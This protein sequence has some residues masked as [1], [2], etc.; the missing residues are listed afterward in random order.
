MNNKTISRL[1]AAAMALLLCLSPLSPALAAEEGQR[2]TI[3]TAEDLLDLADKCRLDAWSQGK[4]VVLTADIS[5]E[6]IDFSGIP[7]F[8][9]TFQGG[10]H[11]ISGLNIT[12]SDAPAGLFR[13]VQP[14]GQIRELNVSGSVSP[15]GTA[16]AVGGIAGENGG[17]ITGCGFTGTVTGK[18]ST[19]G[20][21]G[22]NTASGRV[23]NCWAS[24][25]VTGDR[26]TGGIAG[27][28]EGVLTA[29]VNRAYI[30]TDNADKALHLEDLDLGVMEDLG[31]IGDLDTMSAAADTGGVVGYSSGT[32]DQCSNLG[33]VGYP[34][35]GYNIGG[36]AGRSCGYIRS[37]SNQAAVVGRKDVGGVVG[38]MEPYVVRE[39]T[40]D[41]AATLRQQLDSL[42][43]ALNQA[44]ADAGSG[45]GAL[46]ARLNAMAG[47]ADSAAGAL[48]GIQTNGFLGGGIASGSKVEV[49]L[50]HI[51]QG[52]HGLG[53]GAGVS[54][55]TSINGLTSA[56]GMLTGQMRLLSGEASNLTDAL[57][58]DLL[59]VN[60][61]VEALADT[62]FDTVLS[63]DG[64]IMV[65]SSQ[66]DIDAVTS[67]KVLGCASS[68]GINGDINVGG[69]AGAM[70]LEYALDPE[71]DV[72]SALEGGV[73]RK[74]EMKAILQNCKNTGT[75]EARHS[76]AGGV[77]GKMDL[78]LITYCGSYGDV[79]SES[80]SY[81]GGVAGIASST[82]RRS[83]AKCT[84]SGR[85]YVGG[86]VGS[87]VE[88]TSSGS[89]S[90]VASCVSMVAIPT[91]TQYAGA[92][93]GGSP[94]T[95]L[96]NY[97]ISDDL[98]GINGVS[99]AGIAQPVAYS[100]M[101]SGGIPQPKAAAPADPAAQAGEAAVPAEPQQPEFLP[102]EFRDFTLKFVAD[103]VVL[104]QTGFAYGD[105]F[106]QDFFPPLPQKEGYYAYWDKTDLQELKF[107]TVVSAV[108]VQYN[109]AL[110][111]GG[112]YRTDGR[113]IFFAEGKFDGGGTLTASP[114][115]TTPDAFPAL[116]KTVGQLLREC[117]NGATL[118]RRIEEQWSLSF[119]ADG[120]SVHQI[121]YLSPSGEPEDLEIYVKSG[122]RWKKVKTEAIGS[123]LSFPVEGTSA[124][125]AAISTVPIWW[126]W[127]IAGT[128][129]L[130]LL[131]LGL[132]AILRGRKRRRGRR[133][134]VQSSAAPQAA[135]P[136]SAEAPE[137]SPKH[138]AHGTRPWV[139][140][141][142]ILA[143]LLAGAGITA[144]CF[145]L[146]GMG[147][148]AKAYDILHRY[149]ERSSFAMVL[150]VSGTV[151]GKP[152][153]MEAAV[154]KQKLDGAPVFSVCGD[155]ME[156]FYANGAVYLENGRAY[157]LGAESPDYRQLLTVALALYEHGEV[158]TEKDG[159][160][161]TYT[162]SAEGADAAA[163][164]NTLLP[165]EL[166]EGPQ[167][168]TVSLTAEGRDLVEL[169]FTT[170]EDG[171]LPL[172]LDA[173]LTVQENTTP[174]PVP[175][176]V[177][178]A[179]AQGDQ[180]VE[181]TV[182]TRDLYQLARAWGDLF[183]RDPMAAQLSISANCGP[184]LL[185]DTLD[186]H[187]CRENDLTIGV[188]EKY[189]Y[190][191]YFA[192]SGVCDGKGNGI[193]T[194]DN[195]WVQAGRL[196]EILYA[197]CLN[198]QITSKPQGDGI[199][200]T[201]ALD[202]AGMQQVAYAIAPAAADLDITLERGEISCQV[203]GGKLTQVTAACRGSMQVLLST[204]SAQMQATVDIQ[205]SAADFTVPD[206]VY[207]ALR[208][209]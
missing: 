60:R 195:T 116:P 205:D 86:I 147:T 145:L 207:Q 154:S 105:S 61:Q 88:E 32:I 13:T 81:V 67:G 148:Q 114:M 108:Y 49:D 64:S 23:E 84:L 4:T 50:P 122:A 15:G 166:A 174:Q 131:F 36:I 2:V 206:V 52:G 14:G 155:A 134:A 8:G 164:A 66:T 127:L 200:Y 43:A 115:P 21:A 189:G 76:Y 46:N 118:S 10:G 79:T 191:L 33:G 101:M 150:T 167:A 185:S 121:R 94:G 128:I 109:T 199:L 29:C 3:A 37:C 182:L 83:F 188:V 151:D 82:I 125:M 87:G 194:G 40:A 162:L 130:G 31:K 71:D 117:F 68:G 95:F 153:S 110:P 156:L 59:A 45:M 73:R 53:A 12:G 42:T 39:L 133:A 85:K 51:I 113:P 157:R 104:K 171:S 70:A 17:T 149:T 92:I 63:D 58:A 6:G 89:S 137:P 7:S 78:G 126:V 65:D 144:A 178:E 186:L 192:D 203:S 124:E 152:L 107:D 135:A 187:I 129:V 98:A 97:F 181:D 172:Q 176:A 111:S 136:Q 119:P 47:A 102:E 75:V 197:L 100:A 123:Y 142:A 56:V 204:V 28:S 54:V 112:Q 158:T 48:N 72:S 165:G 190:P 132:R 208:E 25:S 180:A 11:T 139:L 9:G 55:N 168:L 44:I 1:L 22:V 198:A 80:G 27:R 96:E 99:Y 41:T 177:A 201:A 34:H 77:T 169:R 62:V 26:M 170:R 120:E 163:L 209:N 24:G 30:N 69:V 20:V 202:Q 16:A 91:C 138:S 140:P 173:R 159:G 19:G 57:T 35:V 146:P 141:V 5:L 93:S 106:G 183:S 18:Q 38:Q 160:V 175:Q 184:V 74:Y 143:A 196:P 193:S 179:I 103:G 90:T 161:T